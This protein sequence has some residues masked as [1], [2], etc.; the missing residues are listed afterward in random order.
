[1]KYFLFLVSFSLLVFGKSPD[2][3]AKIFVAGHKG[4]VGNAI[5]QEL[6]SQGYTNIITRTSSELDLTDKVKTSAFFNEEKPEYVYLAAAK[7]GGIVANNTHP[8]DFIYKNLMIQT[9]VIDA[10]YKAGVSKLLFLGSSCIYP[11]MCPQPIKE[12]YLLS[13]LLEPTNSAYAV[14]KIAGIEMCKSYKRQYD[15]NSICLMPTNLYGPNDNF[16]PKNSHVMPAFIRRFIEAKE[17]GKDSV[18][19]WGT[20]SACR[21]FLYVDDLAKACVFLM[22][23]YDGDDIINVGTGKDISIKD[24]A[25]LIAEEVGFEGEITHDLSKPD[26]TPKKL[27]NVDKLS[28]LGFKAETSL[29]E[30]VRK[31]IEW[32]NSQKENIRK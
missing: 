26:G 17:Q 12:E 16:H 14:A 32:Y 25:H 21:E 8:A 20:G 9:N 28:N 1:M 31:T 2:F 18:E 6:K 22:K 19:I 23:N 3:D 15:F 24:L 7:V 29:R 11:K 27:L 30:G 10:A 13:G 4:L 5:I